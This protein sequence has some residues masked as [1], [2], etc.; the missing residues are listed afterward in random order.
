[1]TWPSCLK[2]PTS[3]SHKADL[4]VTGFLEILHPI[5]QD[6]RQFG[7]LI[8]P[9]TFLHL[10]FFL[11][12]IAFVLEFKLFHPPLYIH[13]HSSGMRRQPKPKLI[14]SVI[15]SA[16][17]TP[18][19][20]RKSRY[21]AQISTIASWSITIHFMTNKDAYVSL[22]YAITMSGHGMIKPG[23]RAGETVVSVGGLRKM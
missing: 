6:I 17:S 3:G 23:I 4:V 8:Q 18:L 20:R 2:T 7:S 9:A 1:M 11:S 13:F 19:K 21:F 12:C 14:S 5:L 22:L 10:K 16:T 15:G